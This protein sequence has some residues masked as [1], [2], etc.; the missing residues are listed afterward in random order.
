MSARDQA[1]AFGIDLELLRSNLELTPDQRLKKLA[2]MMRFAERLRAQALTP[3][4]RS[5]LERAS[6]IE[7]V[8][9]YGFEDDLQRLLTLRARTR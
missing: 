1:A 8:Q 7:E 6:M 3:E 9:A 4:Q 2:S 5:R